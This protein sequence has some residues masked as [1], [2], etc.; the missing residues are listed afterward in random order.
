MWC[1]ARPNL[2]QATRDYIGEVA[3]RRARRTDARD[4]TDLGLRRE[5]RQADHKVQRN[6]VGR[7]LDLT[8]Q[9]EPTLTFWFVVRVAG[10]I[11]DRHK[12]GLRLPVVR[13]GGGEQRSRHRRGDYQ[14]FNRARRGVMEVL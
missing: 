10:V 14:N 8:I 5:R 3:A 4:E 9:A 2:A 13:G 7:K 12:N 6:L 1:C 11:H